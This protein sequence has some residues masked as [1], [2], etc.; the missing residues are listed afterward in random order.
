MPGAIL[1]AIREISVS[2]P[3]ETAPP[4]TATLKAILDQ[5]LDA[6]LANPDDTVT[7]PELKAKLQRSA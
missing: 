7:W 5:R 6:F 1:H 3:E 2:E 4:L